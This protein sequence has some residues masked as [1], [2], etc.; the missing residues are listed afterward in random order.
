MDEI[1]LNSISNILFF[2]ENLV[3]G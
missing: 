1:S 3:T 2:E